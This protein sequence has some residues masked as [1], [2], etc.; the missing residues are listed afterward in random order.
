[1]HDGRFSSLLEVAEFYNSG[2]QDTP[3]LDFSLREPLQLGLS[4]EQVQQL[5]AYLN[6]LTDET[7]LTS[8]LFSDPFVTLPG[9]YTGDGIVNQA[10]YE[11]W[12]A[13]V[14]DATMLVADGNGDNIVDA[15]DYVLWR[16]NVGLTW[17]TFLGGSGSSSRCDSR[18]DDRHADRIHAH[19]GP[20]SQASH[21]L[22]NGEVELFRLRL[23][24]R[25]EFAETQ[26][27]ADVGF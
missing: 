1:M 4:P 3:T 13:S 15:A 27:F 23:E 11:L 16:S 19:T 6:T 14:G 26:V 2:V 21:T 18:T 9:D 17:Q 12:R 20:H 7:F 10:D 25:K 22:L 24:R 5:A 8:P